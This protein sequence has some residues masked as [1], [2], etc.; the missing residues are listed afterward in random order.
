MYASF[1]QSENQHYLTAEGGLH[2][3]AAGRAIGAQ[4]L[5]TGRTR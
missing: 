1:S 5:G 4:P 3:S 2:P